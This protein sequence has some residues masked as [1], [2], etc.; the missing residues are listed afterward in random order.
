MPDYPKKLIEVALPLAEI[1]DASAYDKMPGIGP[2]PKG[3]HHWWARLPLPSARAV[4]FASVVNDPSEEIDKLRQDAKAVKV[5]KSKLAKRLKA[6][7]QKKVDHDKAIAAGINLPD[8]E[9]QPTVDGILI[10]R[11]REELFGVIREL[12]QKNPHENKEAFRKARKLMEE[13]CEG[14]MPEVLDPFTGGGSIP[15]EAQRLGFKSHGRDLN[16]VPALITRAVIDYPS[17]FFDHPAR[18]PRDKNRQDWRGSQGL[19]E[20]VR[21]YGE[22]MLKEAKSKLACHYPDVDITGAIS[23]GRAELSPYR[24]KKLP[25]IAWLWARTVRCMNPGCKKTTPML[26]TFVLSSKSKKKYINPVTNGGELSIEIADSPPERYADPKKG[27]KRGMSG[28]FECV[29][30]GTVTT[31]DYVANE[32][33]SGNLDHLGIAIVAEGNRER[34]YLPPDLS[35]SDMQIPEIDDRGLCAA[36]SPNPRDVWCRNFG[37]YSP[38]DLFTRRQLLALSTFSE[39]IAL[40]RDQLICD[41]ANEEYA[42]SVSTYLAFTVSRTCDFNN[43][44]CRWAPD[45]QKLMNLFSRQAIPM[46]W[47]YCE[48]NVMRP[49]VGGWETCLG[50]VAKCVSIIPILQSEPGEVVQ[51]DAATTKWKPKSLIISTDPPYYD[52][53]G[54][55]D[56]SDF[57]YVWLRRSLQSIHPSLLGTMMTPKTE[58]LVA[59]SYRHDGGKDAAKEHFEVGFRKAFAGMSEAIDPRFPL[60]VYYAMKQSEGIDGAN[61][62]WETMLTGLIDSGFQITAT[63]PVRAAQNWRMVSMGTNALANYVVLACRERPDDAPMATRKELVRALQLELPGAMRDLQRGNIGTVD[64]FQAAIGPGMAIFSSYSKVVEADGSSM[65]VGHAL[66]IINEHIGEFLDK[67]TGEMDP[68]TRFAVAWFSQNAFAAGEYGDAETLAVARNVSVQGVADAGIIESGAGK[69]RILR[70]DELPEDWDPAEDDRL[71][72]WEIVHHLARRLENDGVDGAATILKRVGGLAEDARA[73]CYR[74]YTTSEQNKWADEARA[75]NT[76]ITEWSEITQRA[77]SLDA[78]ATPTQQDLI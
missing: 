6:W 11:K 2:H 50:Y 39:L 47:D 33:N 69:V 68:W 25:V 75:Y 12:M 60:T 30:C 3:I 31:R 72:V 59:L 55:A 53:I 48:A 70:I 24:G 73:L 35:Q 63:W 76:L 10:E 8:L 9:P 4:L 22:W 14:K 51:Q 49:V 71:T 52:N 29:F 43:S 20:D 54:Y 46:V 78:P 28:I 44:L 15:L 57:F 5:A 23:A 62:G 40:A 42:D 18:N 32:A 27:L 13:A 38:K 61:T 74:L 77:E 26:S 36:L 16:P 34:L 67:Q 41:G 65:S 56:L 64:F 21:Y 1:N 66:Q 7:E 19:A 58:E 45:N 17:R 37:L